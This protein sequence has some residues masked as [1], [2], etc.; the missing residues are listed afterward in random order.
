MAGWDGRARDP[1]AVGQAIAE[2]AAAGEVTARYRPI[3]QR[4]PDRM[5]GAEAVAALPGSVDAAILAP[6]ADLGERQALLRP[7]LDQLVGQ[8]IRE[9]ATPVPLARGWWVTV[10]FDDAFVG[11]PA[12]ARS[13][14]AALEAARMPRSR[15][16][17]ELSERAFGE[18]LRNGTVNHL[19]SSGVQL[20][21]ADF[22]AGWLSPADLRRVPVA[23]VRVPVRGMTAEDPDDLD[24]VRSVAAAARTLAIPVLGDGVETS[25]Q[26]ELVDRCGVELVQGY[27]WGSPGPA[28]KLIER[29]GRD[30]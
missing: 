14:V 5:V 8:V 3:F 4:G 12:P 25:E 2:A 28:A 29:W 15:F 13:L 18:G 26:L 22:G 23:Y 19:V 20:A 1:W 6:M 27:W 16:V 9:L 7:V 10:G 17:V 11:A 24:L 21:V 30:G